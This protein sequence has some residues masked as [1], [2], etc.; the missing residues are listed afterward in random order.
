MEAVIR[1]HGLSK[2][3][4]RKI[5]VNRL[6]FDVPRG[7]IFAFLGDNGAGKTTTIRMLTGLL[8]PDAGWAT[9][10]DEEQPDA[11]T[12]YD[13]HGGYG[14]PDHIQVHRVGRRAA[15]LAGVSSVFEG[16][17]NRDH[18][19][20]LIKE[21]IEASGG[22][23]G[24][25]PDGVSADGLPTNLPSDFGTPEADITHRVDASAFVD[26]KRSSMRCHPPQMAPDH[27]MLAMPD[28]DFARAMG[29]EW[30]IALDGA[31]SPVGGALAGVFEPLH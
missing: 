20:R 16:T 2:C 6:T 31:P 29:T 12:I 26:R 28:D 27:F 5:A 9:I 3:F 1:L 18:L 21:R 17:M 13:D 11:F 7:A 19:V 23:D 25:V 4:G 14:H 24:N 22:A 30:F 15:E 10:L 8:R